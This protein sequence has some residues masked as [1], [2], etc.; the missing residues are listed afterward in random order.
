[1]NCRECFRKMMF[2]FLFFLLYHNYLISL[3]KKTVKMVQ[4]I[5][6]CFL[7]VF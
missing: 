2:P 5:T 7:F 1:M 6:K 4:F 3:H